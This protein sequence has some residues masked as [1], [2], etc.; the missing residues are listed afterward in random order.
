MNVLGV[1][2]HGLPEEKVSVRGLKLSNRSLRLLHSRL[3]LILGFRP[4]LLILNPEPD[5]RF[6]KQPV[7]FT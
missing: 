7:R 5:N 4:R 6:K 2:L 3:N 1:K